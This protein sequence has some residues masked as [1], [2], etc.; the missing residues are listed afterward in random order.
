MYGHGE[1]LRVPWLI[2]RAI[3]QWRKDCSA[4][5]LLTIPIAH[6]PAAKPFQ[7]GCNHIQVAPT[8]QV[9]RHRDCPQNPQPLELTIFF[10]TCFKVLWVQ[11]NHASAGIFGPPALTFCLPLTGLFFSIMFPT[12]TAAVS[13]LQ[14]G[15]TSAILGVF[16][17]FG[18]LGGAL[19]PWA[20][21]AAAD[22]VGIQLAFALNIFFCLVTL[23]TLLV[24]HRLVPA[25]RSR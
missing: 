11:M 1:T 4:T 22:L 2:L 12:A 7:A 8:N 18:G 25:G 16:F 21:G 20:I 15:N 6:Q 13:A 24:I 14:A 5:L 19:G 10:L 9:E 17:T 23:A 3:T